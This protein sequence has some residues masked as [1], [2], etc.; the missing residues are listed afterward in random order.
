MEELAAVG[1]LLCFD[2]SVVEVV[3]DGSEGV[4]G[5]VVVP[6]RVWICALAEELLEDV[7]ISVAAGLPQSLADILPY[8]EIRQAA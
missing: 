7:D 6:R 8:I 1:E 4:E 2:A 3:C 5:R